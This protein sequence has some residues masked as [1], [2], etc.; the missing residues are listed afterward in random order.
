MEWPDMQMWLMCKMPNILPI[1]FNNMLMIIA[2]ICC[3]C[4]RPLQH[5]YNIIM[6]CLLIVCFVVHN[7]YCVSSR[8]N[9]ETIAS[10]IFAI[11][12]RR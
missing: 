6:V 10:V 5:Y 12:M 8:C 11:S 3:T 7:Y 1:I 4:D 2:L 9:S